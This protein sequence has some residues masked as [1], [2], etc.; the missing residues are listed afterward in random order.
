[1]GQWGTASGCSYIPGLFPFKST[2]P[3]THAPDHR[4]PSLNEENA[5][6]AQLRQVAARV[7]HEWQELRFGGA[8]GLDEALIV[9]TRLVHGTTCLGE[10]RELQARWGEVD[11]LVRR[12]L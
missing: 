4:R 12:T 8:P 6:A 11:Q 9:A 1:M 5:L 7:L 10:L 3:P 2:N